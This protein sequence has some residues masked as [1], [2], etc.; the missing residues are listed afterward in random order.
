MLALRLVGPAARMMGQGLRPNLVAASVRTICGQ[1]PQGES[2]GVDVL[3]AKHYRSPSHIESLCGSLVSQ[4]DVHRA[5]E[6]ASG[7]DGDMRLF[8][9]SPLIRH[10]CMNNQAA[11]ALSLARSLGD[12]AL[13]LFCMQC[14]LRDCP[15]YLVFEAL[16]A[17]VEESDTGRVV[18]ARTFVEK[19]DLESAKKLGNPTDPR[20]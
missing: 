10:M 9:Y 14:I 4:G 18:L 19:G 3:D 11:K 7:L 5:R 1:V 2:H 17:M 8:A 6:I 12:K 16:G 20:N 13:D 15:S